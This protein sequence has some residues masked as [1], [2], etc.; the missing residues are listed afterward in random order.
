M[1]WWW[2]VFDRYMQLLNKTEQYDRLLLNILNKT[3]F[4]LTSLLEV[5]LVMIQAVVIV[6]HRH[7]FTV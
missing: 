7:L 4:I 5:E 6:I 2:S 1:A 3:H